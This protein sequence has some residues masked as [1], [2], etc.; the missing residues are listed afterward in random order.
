MVARSHGS[1]S[2]KTNKIEHSRRG[3]APTN[4]QDATTTFFLRE[5]FSKNG[6]N[7]KYGGIS[8]VEQ[9]SIVPT[10]AKHINDAVDGVRCGVLAGTNA[11]T[12]SERQQSLEAFRSGGTQVLVATAA[13]E[14]GLDIKD[15]EFVILY[16]L[17]TTT[18]SSIQRSGSARKNA[19]LYYFENDPDCENRKAASLVAVARDKSLELT[20]EELP[21]QSNGMKASTQSVHPYPAGYDRGGIVNVFNCKDI[22]IKYCASLLGQSMNVSEELYDYTVVPG[23]SQKSLISVRYPTPTGWASIDLSA[24]LAHWKDIDMTEVFVSSRT[25]N[26]SKVHREELK[27]VYIV[28]VMLR[29]A[30]L[31]NM[32]NKPSE[33]AKDLA[34]RRCPLRS[35]LPVD[36]I[37]LKRRVDFFDKETDKTLPEPVLSLE[38]VA[39]V[40]RKYLQLVFYSPVDTFDKFFQYSTDPTLMPSVLN[41]PAPQGLKQKTYDDFARTF[42]TMDLG[43]QLDTKSARERAEISGGE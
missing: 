12:M 35:T 30:G 21:A 25:K 17:C 27:F 42:E 43:D 26:M 3:N 29:K 9:I 38:N 24:M 31:L 4:A 14:E 5:L 37:A 28:D 41:F 34:A 13:A 33:A 8:F 2:N 18:K 39:E 23:H 7:N 16:S 11:Q 36:A 32:N 20:A 19:K 6:A 40:F 15:C 1:F 10:M 22:L